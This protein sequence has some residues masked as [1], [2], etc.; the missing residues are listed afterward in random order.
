M[1]IWRHVVNDLDPK[2]VAAAFGMTAE[3]VFTY[4][5]DRVAPTL[6]AALDGT[7]GQ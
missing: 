5:A 4:F 1:P 6:E 7:V 2:L 3:G